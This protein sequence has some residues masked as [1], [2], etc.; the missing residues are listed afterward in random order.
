M[1]KVMI[2]QDSVTRDANV[3][4]SNYTSMGIKEQKKRN[5]EHSGHLVTLSLHRI[6]EMHSCGRTNGVQT[7]TLG[8]AI[9]R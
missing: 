4:L 5:W 9:I 2:W 1:G 3:K 7:A 6:Q 8:P